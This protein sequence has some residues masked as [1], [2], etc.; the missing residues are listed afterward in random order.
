MRGSQFGSPHAIPAASHRKQFP[1]CSWLVMCCGLCYLV[2]CG[3]IQADVR[4]LTIRWFCNLVSHFEASA[5]C[6]PPLPSFV[7]LIIWSN[8]RGWD[9][10]KSVLSSVWPVS[11]FSIWSATEI[12][13]TLTP[14]QL[15]KCQNK[16]EVLVFQIKGF[17]LWSAASFSIELSRSSDDVRVKLQFCYGFQLGKK[18]F[19]SKQ[20]QFS[21]TISLWNPHIPYQANRSDDEWMND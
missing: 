4:F 7:C 16:V 5:C 10:S 21:L 19:L 12:H 17:M 8:E 2:S 18:V 6:Y 3:C 13:S 15:L 14:Q 20:I 9:L 11:F 1:L